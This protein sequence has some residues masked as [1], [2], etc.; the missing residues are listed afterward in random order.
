M[1]IDVKTGTYN[2][3]D[4][5]G[6]EDCINEYKEFYLHHNLSLKDIEELKKGIFNKK[7]LKNVKDTL[8]NDYIDKYC[9][10]YILSLSNID[11]MLLPVVINDKHSNFYIGVSDDGFMTGIPI[12]INMLDKLKDDIEKKI[13]E[14]FDNFIG[15]HTN[16]G[17]KEILIGF[18]TFYNFDTILKIIK[19]HTKI[20]IHILNKTKGRGKYCGQLLEYIDVIL[21]EEKEYLIEKEYYKTMI[22]MKTKYNERYNL[23]FYKLIRSEVMIEFMNFTQMEKTDFEKILFLMQKL[24]RKRKDVYKYL[25]NGFY[26]ENSFFPENPE[27]DKYY[28]NLAKIFLK[29]YAR[30]KDVQMAKNITIKKSNKR[31][32]INKLNGLLSNVSCFSDYFYNVE[33]IIWVVIKLEVLIIKDPRCFLGVRTENSDVSIFQRTFNGSPST[34]KLY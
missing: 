20:N 26:I 15:L 12:H 5:L 31:S 17:N 8:L 27:E 23:P 32:P 4:S 13:N 25:L 21:E 10:K 22:K 2:L 14:Y 6:E 11:K 24:I 30:F 16:K 29:E 18:D 34:S 28:G 33:D 1:N 3:Y 9:I 19:K 7:I